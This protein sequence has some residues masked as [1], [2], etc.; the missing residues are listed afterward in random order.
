M[1]VGKIREKETV[2][3]VAVGKNGQETVRKWSKTVKSALFASTFARA[4]RNPSTSCEHFGG[5]LRR[6][7]EHFG[8]G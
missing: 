1:T 8:G 5:F 4:T 2:I 3:K 6:A 7:A